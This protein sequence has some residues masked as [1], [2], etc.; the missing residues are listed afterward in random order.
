MSDRD[1][2]LEVELDNDGVDA[3]QLTEDQQYEL[4]MQGFSNFAEQ[5]TLQGFS[6]EIVSAAQFHSFVKRMQ[7]DS[8]REEFE[9]ILALALEQDWPE[10]PSIH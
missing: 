5:L 6:P 10:P 3:G 8:D 1:L 9:E 7:Q 2:S 4:C